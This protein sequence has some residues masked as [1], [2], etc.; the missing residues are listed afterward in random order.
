MNNIK[1]SF[2]ILDATADWLQQEK[3]ETGIIKKPNNL[4]LCPVIIDTLKKVYCQEN[5]KESQYGGGMPYL[6]I[7]I[8]TYAQILL[9]LLYKMMRSSKGS[10]EG[11]QGMG[12]PHKLVN[13]EKVTFEFIESLNEV[14]L[15]ND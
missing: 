2:K 7:T 14:F 6:Q 4:K 10:S 13:E 8:P 3:Q 11:F 9:Q 12:V 5:L 15:K 1:E